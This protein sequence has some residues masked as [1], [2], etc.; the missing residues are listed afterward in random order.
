MGSKTVLRLS[1]GKVLANVGP[2]R[3]AESF[4]V[5]TTR[6]RVSVKGTLFE[7]SERAPSDVSVSV[8]RGLVAVSGSDGTW[9][10][11]AGKSWHSLTPALLGADETSTRDR[12]LLEEASGTVEAR[13][14]IRVDGPAGLEI[15][16]GGIDL[17]PTPVT[18]DAPIGRYHFVATAGAA[19]TEGDAQ[20]LSSGTGTLLAFNAPTPAATIP[21]QA[22]GAPV[23]S[24]TASSEVVPT[25]PP[26]GQQKHVV[27]PASE[28]PKPRPAPQR[29]LDETWIPPPPSPA[30]SPAK[31]T[32]VA[33]LE[34]EGREAKSPQNGACDNTGGAARSVEPSGSVP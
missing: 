14:T 16:E 17:G 22:G 7:V 4:L 28:R 30:S 26:S 5:Q 11:P 21:T 9:E 27:E 18:W 10:V 32:V 25:P 8:T 2:R 23:P 31:Q 33:H 13:A 1:H 19:R 6:Y 34:P 29:V 15:S 3:V 24:V 20:T 12:D